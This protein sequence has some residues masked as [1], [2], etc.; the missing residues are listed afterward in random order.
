MKRFLNGVNSDYDFFYQ[1]SL[2]KRTHG[3]LRFIYFFPLKSTSLYHISFF[4]T[5]VRLTE[6]EF[7]FRQSDTN[8]FNID[9]K[10]CASNKLILIFFYLKSFI[11]MLMIKYFFTCPLLNAFSKC[12]NN[13]SEIGFMF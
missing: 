7:K 11:L 1:R 3:G 10:E 12:S 8:K 9:E 2:A 5:R 4:N 13:F 6:V